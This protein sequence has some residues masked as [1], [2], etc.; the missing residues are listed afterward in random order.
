MF[1]QNEA[2][3]LL[4]ARQGFQEQ[5]AE[6]SQGLSGLWVQ[7]S[8]RACG[9]STANCSKPLIAL[10]RP[11][12]RVGASQGLNSVGRSRAWQVGMCAPSADILSLHASR[13]HKSKGRCSC[14]SPFQWS[15][16]LTNAKIN[17]IAFQQNNLFPFAINKRHI[18]KENF[19]WVEIKD[20]QTEITIVGFMGKNGFVMWLESH[21]NNIMRKG[22]NQ[23]PFFHGN[24]AQEGFQQTLFSQK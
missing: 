10:G 8:L 12:T 21:L 14:F 18:G 15:C 3:I 11:L 13:M 19:L 24:E 23:T 22:R 4:A 7:P 9:R 16:A 6:A 1:H 2:L 5:L 17:K 20:K